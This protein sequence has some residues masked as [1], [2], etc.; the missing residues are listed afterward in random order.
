MLRDLSL[1]IRAG[2]VVGLLGPNGA[3]KTTLLE[4]IEGIQ[5]PTLGEV[6]VFGQPPRA[7][8]A[9]TRANVGFVFQRNALPDHATVRQLISLYSSV[10]GDQ[11]HQQA[12]I[13]TLGLAHLLG[14]TIGELSVGQRQRLSVFS[15]LV[16]SPSLLIMDEP[17][18]ALDLRS[19]RAVWDVI[20]QAKRGRGLS[21]LIATHDMEEA[22]ALCDRV[23]F[24]DEGELRGGMGVRDGDGDRARVPVRFRAPP[25]FVTEAP[26]LANQDLA[27]DERSRL[28]LLHCPRHRLVEV[29]ACLVEVERT[30]GFDTQLVVGG[31]ALEAAYLSHVETAE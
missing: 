25:G 19:R 2:E 6:R 18:S 10:F 21:G 14:R 8:D 3:G 11:P 20:V 4:T 12:L 28:Y 30:R 29:V 16:S 1:E 31:N 15:S 23:V 22:D 5:S 7:L 26:A 24:I 17:T 13:D 9:T 27:F